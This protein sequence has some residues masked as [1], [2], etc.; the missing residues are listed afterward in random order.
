MTRILRCAALLAL[1]AA[2]AFCARLTPASATIGWLPI[3]PDDLALKDNP[4]EPGADAMIL[5]REVTVDARKAN[6]SGDSIEEYIRVKIFTKAG[7]KYGHVDIPY[8][9]SFETVPYIA[10]R[11]IFPDG[12]IKEFDG[13]ALNSTIARV[14]QAEYFA[15]TFTLPDVQPGCIVEYRFNREARPGWLH[16]EEWTLSSDMY[17]REA[18]FTY[19]PNDEFDQNGYHAQYRPYLLPAGAAMKRNIDTSYT[20]DLHDIPAVVDEPMMPPKAVLEPSVQFYYVVP[21]Q[22]DPADP[23]KKFWAHYAKQWDG[24]IS[25]FID[26]QDAL[27]QELS[28]I[29]AAGDSPET[30]LRKIYARVEQLR[31]LSME[32]YKTE[33]ETKAEDLTP[34]KNVAD[35]LQHGYAT[36]RQVNLT[37]IGLARAAGFDATEVFVAPRNSSIFIANQNDVGELRDELV[38]VKAGTQE[39]YLDPSAR[40]YP[41]G[42]LPWYESEAGGIRVDGHTPTFVATP[43]PTADQATIQRTAIL[44]V[45]ADGS[46][47]ANVQVN[48]TGLE[49]AMLREQYRKE[50]Q[51]GRTKNLESEIQKWLPVG[52]Q[53]AITKIDNW[54][55]IEKPVHVEGTLQVPSYGSTTAR[56]M[57]LPMDIFQATQA[58]AFSEQMRHNPIYFSYPYEEIDDVTVNAPSGYKI[59][60]LPKPQKIDLKAVVYQITPSAQGNSVEIRRQLTI[61]GVLFGKEAYPTFRTF[62]GAVRTNDN[63]Q[64]VLE[65]NQTGQLQ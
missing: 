31:N 49:G 38:W 45:K 61:G 28:K 16:D 34:D 26:K 11:T 46:I 44:N 23:P 37:F 39:Y 7:T 12:T 33:K 14:G 54:D 55:D 4:K 59:D 63:A 5:Y 25:H 40:F 52:S 19:Y 51:T 27:N 36:G 62:F 10:G 15:K 1:I 64:M 18:H 58:G 2:V 9:P 65:N 24:E 13:Q 35:V 48:F 3:S 50:D 22:P 43:N 20:M 17:T 57:L 32:D 41:F 60:A 47:T 29:V 30:K 56:D 21:G 53:L 8:D 42:V 6:I